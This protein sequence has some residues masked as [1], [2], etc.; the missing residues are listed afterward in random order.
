MKILMISQYFLPESGAAAQRVGSFAKYLTDFGHDVTIICQTP[1]Y[2]TGEVYSG[3]QNKFRHTAKENNYRVVRSF[4]YPTRNA[5]FIKRLINYLIFSVTAFLNGLLEPR[6]DLIL[7]SSPPLFTGGSA[8]LLSLLKQVPLVVDIRDIWPGVALESGVGN[9]VVFSP[10][11]LLEKILYRRATLITTVSEGMV[12]L[13]V[14]ENGLGRDKVEAVYNGFDLQRFSVG[15]S[16]SVAGA[17]NKFTVVYSGTIGIQQKLDTLLEAVEILK[18]N[19]EIRFLI[20]GEGVERRALENKIANRNLSNVEFLGLLPYD[21][22]LEV[23]GDSDLSLVLLTHNKYNDPALPSK[24]FDY[25][26]SGIPVLASA[27]K[28][29]KEFIGR[30]KIGF[31]IEPENPQKLADKIQE[32]SKLPRREIQSM[33]ERGRALVRET[34]N[35]EAQAKRLER[36]LSK[37][38]LRVNIK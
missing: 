6:P 12:D 21:K 27:G 11:R 28:F 14:E 10:L 24:V 37:L 3:F 31:W 4:T 23:I 18:R 19:S 30:E 7:V 17:R 25:C 9:R 16:R 34:Y 5:G 38:P 20:C 36:M 1:N 26:F 22:S 35:R 13:L 29:L 2:P 32:V 33:G 8:L 15:K